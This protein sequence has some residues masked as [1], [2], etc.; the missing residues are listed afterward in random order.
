MSTALL[1]AFVQVPYNDISRMKC[2]LA[3]MLVGGSNVLIWKF[4]PSGKDENCAETM[5]K[6]VCLP[7]L[8]YL[9]K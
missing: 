3:S 6:N 1:L 7:P 9:H 4:F 5:R 8:W 2:L